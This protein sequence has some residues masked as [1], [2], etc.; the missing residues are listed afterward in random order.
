MA[1]S[2]SDLGLVEQFAR[3]APLSM[4]EREVHFARL[5]S[6][7]PA[8]VD[9][10][11]E[12]LDHHDQAAGF[13][14]DSPER[15]APGPPPARPHSIGGFRIL[16]ELGWG[17]M[18]VVYLAEQERPR[19]TV[20]LKVLRWDRYA[21]LA[22]KRFEREAEILGRLQHDN[23]ARI[24]AAGVDSI[25]GVDVPWFAMERIEGV[26]IDRACVGWTWERVVETLADVADGIQVA[27]AA[28]IIHRDLKASNV[29]VTSEGRAVVL[30]FG[31]A[32]ITGTDRSTLLTFS[33]QIVG[34]LATMSP[35]QAEGRVE[36]VDERSDV[37]ALGV[38]LFELLVGH[39]PI[40]LSGL[41]PAS[42]IARISRT[43]PRRLRRVRPDLPRDLEVLA[44][45]AL[46][47]DPELRPRTAGEFAD[48]LRRTV[49]RLP[50]RARRAT[51]FHRLQSLVRRNRGLFAGLVA[52]FVL[53]SIA[54]GVTLGSLGKVSA[55]NRSIDH[56]AALDRARVLEEQ[57]RSLWPADP[58]RL[59]DLDA[60]L[61]EA[62]RLAQR[63]QPQL[64]TTR[65][66]DRPVGEFPPR[67]R[68]PEEV[69]TDLFDPA[70]E[71]GGYY[72]VLNRRGHAAARDAATVGALGEEW[73]A[74][75]ERIAQAPT[76]GGLVIE[77]QPGLIPL[78]PDPHSGLEEFAVWGRAGEIPER[79]GPDDRIQCTSQTTVVLVLVPGG[80]F[81]FGRQAQ[82]PDGP[83]YDPEALPHEWLGDRSHLTLAPFLI[84][85]FETTQGQF[86]RVMGFNT[87][88]WRPG[89][90]HLD[91]VVT[92]RHPVET[93]RHGEAVLF[94]KH[95]GLDLP[96][97]AQFEFANRAGTDTIYWFGDRLEAGR[98]LVVDTSLS[99]PVD[100][101]D[102]DH[103]GHWPVLSLHAP[104]GIYAANAFGLHD[105]VGNVGEWCREEYWGYRERGE[106][107]PAT[108]EYRHPDPED[109]YG[110]HYP[111]R[112][113][114]QARS[115]GRSGARNEMFGLETNRDLGFRTVRALSGAWQV[116]D[117]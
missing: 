44:S 25:A 82:D 16:D 90:G 103:T 72:D 64:S 35:E 3:L 80:S 30:D 31:I 40:D 54:L 85:K 20:A 37:Y 36:L 63:L 45:A 33:G 78:G 58:S 75:I 70:R 4:K 2:E 109:T 114:G 93:V 66:R 84:S 57:A 76:Y 38:M 112:H 48:D 56:N 29:L 69:A 53:L 89:E 5:R 62:D 117:R 60:W 91:Y 101:V 18:G 81:W 94:G 88:Y 42:A 15:M 13:L 41:D 51:G 8:I 34:T 23:L 6:A 96:T 74:T 105:T 32:A 71:H 77:P 92:A 52:T 24:Y 110:P 73:M 7:V 115:A 1:P 83:N 28:G 47:K 12:L 68:E 65:W 95:I 26:P 99:G 87:S 19:R 21:P 9:E 27:H 17:G 113:K 43:A 111:V 11:R 67:D 97:E 116:G 46:A 108:G 50:V 106:F 10:L 100:F 49:A 79:A 61:D 98:D 22:V 59:G 55:L 107:N 86:E 39:S 14:E 104:V 102:G